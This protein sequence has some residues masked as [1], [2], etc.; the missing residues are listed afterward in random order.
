[1][2]EHAC[3]LAHKT[4]LNSML[5]SDCPADCH[6][7]LL[8]RADACVLL[9]LHVPLRHCLTLHVHAVG[10]L[11]WMW[12]CLGIARHLLPLI[13]CPWLALAAD[14]LPLYQQLSRSDKLP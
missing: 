5:V 9:G 13:P 10:Q 1:M 7:L 14:G 3:R 6:R 8:A 12:M 11:M 4:G 2:C